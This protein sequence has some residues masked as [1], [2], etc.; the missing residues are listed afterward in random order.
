MAT[1][2]ERVTSGMSA[3]IA[4]ARPDGANGANLGSRCFVC[5][6]EMLRQCAQ[7]D[8]YN[9]LECQACKLQWVANDVNEADIARFYAKEYYNGEL[10]IGYCGVAYGDL[11][12][13]HRRNARRLLQFASAQSRKPIAQANVLDVGCGYGFL[14]DEARQAGA[15]T[16]TGVELSAYAAEHA[17]STLGL[18]V[19]RGDVTSLDLPAQSIDFAFMIGTIE[20]FIRPDLVVEATARLLKPGGCLVISTID[21]AGNIPIYAFKPPEHLFYFNRV[22]SAALLAKYSLV[23]RDCK[24]LFWY[25]DLLDVGMRLAAMVKLPRA[26]ELLKLFQ[27]KF[28]RLPCLIPTNEMLIGAIKQGPTNE[29]TQDRSSRAG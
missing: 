17:A 24:S 26:A 4:V 27:S 13:L 22:S 2:V 6:S 1:D 3:T 19:H 28:V 7:R 8:H 15:A 5:Q 12:P 9:I 16:C 14:L 18:N 20:H 25:H 10:E 29:M 23:V 11:E 21:T